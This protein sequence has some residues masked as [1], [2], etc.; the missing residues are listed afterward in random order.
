MTQPNLVIPKPDNASY[1]IAIVVMTIIGIIATTVISV[2]RPLQDNIPLI[3]LLLGNIASVTVA[4]L[5][6]MKSQET[7]LSVNSRLDGFI[8]NA[9]EASK[10]QGVVEGQ[11]MAN[12]RT[13]SLKR[14]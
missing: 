3:T 8:K 14:L 1:M 7:H 6:Y 5:A 4:L 12:E 11:Q 9:Q 2:L 10:A 13:D